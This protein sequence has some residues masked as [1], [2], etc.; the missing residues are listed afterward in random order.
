MANEG[1]ETVVRPVPAPEEI[2]IA[3]RVFSASRYFAVFAV[4]GAFLA[5]VTLYIYGSLVVIQ[6]IWETLGEY[7][8]SVEGVKHLQ[9]VFIEMTDVFLLGTVL[10]IVSFGLY[11][12][13]IQPDLPV[14]SWLRIDHLDQLTERLVEVVGVLL[15]V[16]FLAIAVEG[17][18]ETSLLEFG[19][20][21]AVVIAA[22]SLLLLV[23]H[24]NATRRAETPGE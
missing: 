3:R 22:L 21:V 23:T 7:R 2:A 20:A 5:S 1:R 18:A 10:F 8:I 4:L 11:Q 16:T 12:L 15:S 9:V 14:P 24:R 13:F 6:L 17:L 19:A